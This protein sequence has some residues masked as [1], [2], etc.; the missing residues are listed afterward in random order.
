M[1]S[2][3]SRRPST[4]STGDGYQMDRFTPGSSS[5]TT[6][7]STTRPSSILKQGLHEQDSGNNNNY[8]YEEEPQADHDYRQGPSLHDDSDLSN[9]KHGEVGKGLQRNLQA[10]HLTMISL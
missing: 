4:G 8:D 9:D 7:A 5:G 3:Y 6:S 2:K 10:R 1:S